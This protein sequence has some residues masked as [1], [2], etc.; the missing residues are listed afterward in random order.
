MHLSLSTYCL[1]AFMLLVW[2]YG[3]LSCCST[4]RNEKGKLMLKIFFAIIGAVFGV[5]GMLLMIVVLIA[6]AI[7]GRL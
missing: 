7:Q 4:L 1:L 2:L 6:T 5:F 3:T